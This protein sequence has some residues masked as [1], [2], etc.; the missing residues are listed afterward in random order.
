MEE[1]LA[2]RNGLARQLCDLYNET[3]L[4]YEAEPE[5]GL[6]SRICGLI[7]VPEA[8]RVCDTA[9]FPSLHKCGTHRIVW[10]PLEFCC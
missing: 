6:L 3:A 8:V 9:R 7:P 2:K 4:W 5:L 1:D 10:S